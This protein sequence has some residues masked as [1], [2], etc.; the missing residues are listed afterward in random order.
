MIYQI[1]YVE[2]KTR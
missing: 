1:K 2:G